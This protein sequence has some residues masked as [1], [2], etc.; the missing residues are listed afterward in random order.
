MATF[1]PLLRPDKVGP[2]GRAPIY[3]AVRHAGKK[4]LVALNLR[5]RV[6][7]WNVQRHEARKTEPEH[8]R[9]N[10]LL[11]QAVAA[12]RSA[13]LDRQANREPITA[14]ALAEDVRVQVSP[15]VGEPDNPH[16]AADFLAF[17]RSLIEGYVAR[18]QTSTAKAHGTAI[19]RLA[20][21]TG[22]RLWRATAA[23]PDALRNQGPEGLTCAG[24]STT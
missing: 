16:E 9:V 8:N 21:F 23:G 11:G 4:R 13:L 7:D 3:L 12:G 5:V 14:E 20:A 19:Q 24:A 15:P 2:D 1:T 18:G 6:R 17:Y 10:D 22:G